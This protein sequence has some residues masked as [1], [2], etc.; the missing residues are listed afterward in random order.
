[1]SPEQVNQ[2]IEQELARWP[3]WSPAELSLARDAMYDALLPLVAG[4][5]TLTEAPAPVRPAEG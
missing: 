3:L 2:L 5:D 1:M 4:A